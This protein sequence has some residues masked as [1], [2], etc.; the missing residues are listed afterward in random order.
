MLTKNKIKIII[1]CLL[2]FL[3]S[4]FN[5]YADE[6]NIVAKEILIDKDNETL[7]GKGSVQAEDLDGRVIYADKIIYEKPKEFL[8]AEGNVKI[9][10][11]DGNI[12]KTDMATYDKMKNI[13]FT[14]NNT[15]LLLK[16]GYKIRAKNGHF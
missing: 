12:L 2:S 7:I 16:E 10:D 11:A 14:Y 6:F 3:I 8:S 1:I 13:I 5:L 15:E 4:K 9:A